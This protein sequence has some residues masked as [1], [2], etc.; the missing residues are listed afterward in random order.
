MVLGFWYPPISVL[1]YGIDGLGTGET[2]QTADAHVGRVGV[3]IIDSLP[4]VAAEP[5]LLHMPVKAFMSGYGL[6]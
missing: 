4:W 1:H 5:P 2:P 6:V 3:G